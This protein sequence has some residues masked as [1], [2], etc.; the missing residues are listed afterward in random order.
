MKKYI[1]LIIAAML[2]LASCT[3]K[4]QVVI[5]GDISGL[6]NVTVFLTVRE[7]KSWVKLDSC[8]IDNGKFQL[9]SIVDEP[10]L[11]YVMMEPQNV[12]PRTPI[13]LEPGTMTIT[14]NN[15]NTNIAFKGSKL[16]DE[17]QSV[18]E[19]SDALEKSYEEMLAAY[20]TA[21]ESRNLMGMASAKFQLDEIEN[22]QINLKKDYIKEN[23]KSF[24]SLIF[25]TSELIYYASLQELE[26]YKSWIDPSL[27]NTKAMKEIDR[28]ITVLQRFEPGQIVPEIA[29]PD[30]AGVVRKLSDLRGKYVMV[31]FW[32]SWCRPCRRENPE[33]VTVYHQFNDKGFDIFSVSLDENREAWVNAIHKDNLTWTHVSELKKWHGEVSSEFCINSIPSNLIIDPEGIIIARNVFGKELHHIIDKLVTSQHL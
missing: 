16:H 29:L 1:F 8:I 20:N 30:T 27:Y 7:N 31:D 23:P 15:D 26:L 32:A 33:K 21:Q 14:S 6:D 3:P 17:F 11:A 2:L 10:R 12:F 18:M 19:Q 25:I 4:N 9:K 28:R 24:V 22:Q 5:T 13:L